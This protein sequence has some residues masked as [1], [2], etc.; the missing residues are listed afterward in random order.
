MPYHE[1]RLRQSVVYNLHCVTDTS[2]KHSE[3]FGGVHPLAKTI[4]VHWPLRK[5]L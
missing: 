1:L 2:D 3:T 5:P 4:R